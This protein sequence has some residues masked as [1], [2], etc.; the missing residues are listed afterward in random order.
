MTRARKSEI[1]HRRERAL[2]MANLLRILEVAGEELGEASECRPCALQRKFIQPV[3][4]LLKKL[5]RLGGVSR[6]RAS[7]LN[8]NERE[9]IDQ[10]CGGYCRVFQFSGHGS[11]PLFL[12][13][14]G[15]LYR[16]GEPRT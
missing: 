8:Q 4:D 12:L 1:D 10:I 16:I 15:E 9:Q 13:V 7:D 11:I 6:C 2:L 3:C 14:G 5:V